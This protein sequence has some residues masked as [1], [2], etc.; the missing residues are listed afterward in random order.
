MVTELPDNTRYRLFEKFSKEST[1]ITI[2]GI[3]LVVAVL[4]LLMAWM[5]VYDSTHVKIQQ[6]VVLESNVELK[7]EIRLLQNKIDRYEANLHAGDN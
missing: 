3:S 1:G 4:S 5:A 2:A 7:R 6:Q